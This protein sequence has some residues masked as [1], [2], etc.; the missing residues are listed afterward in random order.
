MENE[1][2]FFARDHFY[3]IKNKHMANGKKQDFMYEKIKPNPVVVG[4]S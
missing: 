4:K 2:Y 1:L 3:F